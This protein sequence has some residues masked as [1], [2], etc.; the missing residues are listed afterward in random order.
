[1]E[2]MDTFWNFSIFDPPTPHPAFNPKK[3]PGYLDHFLIALMLNFMKNVQ[4]L[5]HPYPPLT[6]FLIPKSTPGT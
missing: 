3:Y 2:H 4:F 6:Q 5:I 1:M